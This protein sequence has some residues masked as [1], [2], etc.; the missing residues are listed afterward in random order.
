MYYGA[1]L[2]TEKELAKRCRALKKESEKIHSATGTVSLKSYR[3]RL[4]DY[5]TYAAVSQVLCAMAVEGLVNFYGVLRFGEPYYKRYLERMR[6]PDKLQ[7]ILKLADGVSISPNDP[8][9]RSLALVSAARNDLVHPKAKEYELG[10]PA[11]IAEASDPWPAAL[12][13]SIT[14]MTDFYDAFASH[15]A[16]TRSA[17]EFFWE[18]S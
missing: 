18:R 3:R 1:A 5:V 4:E 13:R 7:S 2:R 8:L 6:M 9:L 10:D 11:S 14:A 12:R 17:T 15:S 16:D